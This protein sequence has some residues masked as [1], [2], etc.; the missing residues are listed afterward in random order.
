[1][2]TSITYS[3]IGDCLLAVAL[4]M[5]FAYVSRV[6]HGL[7]GIAIWGGGHLVYTFGCTLLDAGRNLL[8][9]HGLPVQAWWA[10]N[11]GTLV[12]CGGMVV[13]AWAVVQ[14]TRQRGLRAGELWWLPA[15]LAPPLLAWI[16]SGSARAQGV[17]LALVEVGS[18]ALVAWSLRRLRQVPEVV[19]AR[20]MLACSLVL[21]LI[22]GLGAAGWPSGDFGLP[23]LWVNLDLSLWFML[24]FCM[25]MLASFRAAEG[26]RQSAALDPLTGALNRRGLD[27]ALHARGAAPSGEL[28]VLGLDLDR[29][30]AVN[31]QYGHAAGDRVLRAFAEAV[32][33]CIGHQDLFA[34]TGG[35]E[36]W[37]IAPGL[38]EPRARV[39]A[40]RIRTQV[41]EMHLPA[42]DLPAVTVSIGVACHTGIQDLDLLMEHADQALYAAKR[43]GRNRVLLHVPSP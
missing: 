1:M 12:A 26:Q 11:L 9:Q 6:S 4:Y 43:A 27:G 14:F 24:N 10:L 21:M 35:E 33:D 29:F 18:L 41:A 23:E 32:R 5:L 38:D 17:A 2:S 37:V 25:L 19:P 22:Y 13:L 8:A 42:P 28:A 31:D 40:D 36:F 39:L 30:K 20:I 3:L 16:A 15:G 34:R 7:R